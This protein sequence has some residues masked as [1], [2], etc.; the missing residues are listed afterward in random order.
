MKKCV[1]IITTNRVSK[2]TSMSSGVIVECLVI[3]GF[4]IL[5]NKVNKYVKLRKD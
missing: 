4:K 3:K 5:I 1:N 2:R